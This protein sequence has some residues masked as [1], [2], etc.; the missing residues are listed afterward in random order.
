M[1]PGRAS[2]PSP[3][4]L[5]QARTSGSTQMVTGT[6]TSARDQKASSSPQIGNLRVIHLLVF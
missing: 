4:A 5:N 1:A 6:T 2:Y 3:W